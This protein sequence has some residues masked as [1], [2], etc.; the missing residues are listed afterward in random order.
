MEVRVGAQ[1]HPRAG[2]R[3]LAPAVLPCQPAACQRAVRRVAETFPD[4]D[5]D[6]FLLVLAFEQGVGVLG[7]GRTAVPE[8]FLEPGGVDV[9]AAVRLDP[10]FVDELG[11][12][13]DRLGD[14][15]LRI[16]GVSEVQRYAVDAEARQAC[17]DLPADPLARET[18]VVALGHRV[19]RLRRQDD[20]LANLGAFRPKPAADERLAATAAVRVS[21][22]ESRDSGFPGG[23]H[24]GMRLRLRSHPLRRTRATNRCRRSCRS[25]G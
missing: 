16:H 15:N 25:R 5:P 14:G 12:R 3:L 22:V 9:A 11:K 18:A 17:L 23:I 20:P 8:C 19:E 7:P 24:E 4:A 10:A 13:A 2:G 1:R 6:R 21:G